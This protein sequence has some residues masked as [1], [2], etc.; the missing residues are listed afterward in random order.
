M[1]PGFG[2]TEL[3]LESEDQEYLKELRKKF[4]ETT[5]NV[6]NEKIGMLIDILA[7]GISER[8]KLIP[9]FALIEWLRISDDKKHE[10]FAIQ[11]EILLD[12]VYVKDH[13][14]K[15]VRLLGVR[16][17]INLQYTITQATVSEAHVY[18]DSAGVTKA[19]SISVD[20][21]NNLSSEIIIT[22]KQQ[23]D[24]YLSNQQGHVQKLQTLLVYDPKADKFSKD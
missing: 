8:K 15:L 16:S 10:P 18:K 11:F 13:F 9:N 5:F 4:D 1:L 2:S 14:G 21:G 19:N 3:F 7:N 6:D 23:P 24:I 20:V 17:S 22:D 12:G